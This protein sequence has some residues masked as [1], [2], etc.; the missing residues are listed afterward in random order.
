MVHRA[1]LSTLS[2]VYATAPAPDALER[3]KPL[4]S[5]VTT[6]LVCYRHG[7]LR[8]YCGIILQSLHDQMCVHI[9][10]DHVKAPSDEL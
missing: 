8:V 3:A 4:L 9:D 1:L 5:T 6:Q 10:V 7:Y 2:R